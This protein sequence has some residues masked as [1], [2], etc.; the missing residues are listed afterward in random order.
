MRAAIIDTYS[1]NT[2]ETSQIPDSS[3]S[4]QLTTRY[5]LRVLTGHGS[6]VE[7]FYNRMGVAEGKSPLEKANIY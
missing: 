6:S 3:H 4:L 7:L 1:G 5:L 2:S